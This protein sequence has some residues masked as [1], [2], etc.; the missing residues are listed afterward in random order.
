[1]KI[2]TAVSQGEILMRREVAVE[3]TTGPERIGELADGGE[4]NRASVLSTLEESVR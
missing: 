3:K 1:M 4:L 2:R